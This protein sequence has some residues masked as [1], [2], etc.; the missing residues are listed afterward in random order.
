MNPAKI[1]SNR[2][3]HLFSPIFVR[4]FRPNQIFD[5]RKGIHQN[6]EINKVKNIRFELLS[7]FK[8]LLIT[9]Y[10]LT[11]KKVENSRTVK[12]KFYGKTT[13]KTQ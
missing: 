12:H 11:E 7:Q 4:D 6:C 8:S 3:K 2:T 1:C 5:L 13:I 9:I 10:L